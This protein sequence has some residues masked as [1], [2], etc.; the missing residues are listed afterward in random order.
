MAEV[1]NRLLWAAQFV[2]HSVA[3]PDHFD[4]DQDPAF[5]LTRVTDPGPTIWYGYGF[6]PFLTGN[7]PKTVLFIHLG[8]ILLFGRS[9]ITQPAGI[10]C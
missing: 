6:L 9:V 7:I 4:T 10:R 8:L 5:H 1:C 3:D 2:V